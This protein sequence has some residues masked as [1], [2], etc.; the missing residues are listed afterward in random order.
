MKYAVIMVPDFALH[1]L[2]RSEPGLASKPVALIEGDGR[3]AVLTEVSPEAATVAP[4]TTATLAMARCPGIVLRTRNPCDAEDSSRLLTAAAFTLSPRIEVTSSE[5][6]TIDLQGADGQQTEA[7]MHRCV[8][9]LTRLGLPARAGAGDTP[10]LALYAARCA[11]PV[12]VIR[13]TQGFLHDLPVGFAEPTPAQ[14]EVLE[15][16]G[17]TTLGRLAALP[18]AEIGRRLGTDAAALW[19]RAAGQ[20]TRVLRLFPPPVS[21]AAQWDYE[22]P[23]ESLEPLLFKLRRYAECLASELRAAGC[24]AETLTLSFKLEDDSS[25]H[26]AFRLAEPGT[27]VDTWLKVLLAHLESLH[28]PAR[29]IEVSLRAKPVRAAVK[30]DG[31][32]D[33]GLRDPLVFWENL[34]RVAAIIGDDRVG[35][36]HLADTWR[37]DSFTLEKPAQSIPAPAAPPLHPAKGGVLRR[38]RPPRPVTVERG[39]GRPTQLHGTMNGM[40]RAVHGPW[41]ASGQWWSPE[42]WGVETWHIELDDAVY[43]LARIGTDWVIEGEVD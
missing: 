13:H 7:A 9:E 20:A 42:A 23:I 27:H 34:S 10:L 3:K 43:Q 33:T 22:P 4:G 39:H 40:I 37:P 11:Q 35:T 19:E 31:L 15:N 17:I 5:V 26:R 8:L 16:W 28:L 24:V 2:R 1:A 29:L 14:A 30:Q 36:P 32:F 6:R 21:Y 38:F 12:L 25:H 18:K 41:R